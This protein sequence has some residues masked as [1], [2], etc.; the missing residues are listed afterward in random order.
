VSVALAGGATG[1]DFSAAPAISADGNRIAFTS[2]ATNVGVGLDLNGAGRDIFVRDMT[3]GTAVLASR[4]T[5][6]NGVSGNGLSERASISADGSRVAFES[7][8]TDLAP[9]DA[10]GAI[11]IF[12]RDTSAE[13]LE[14]VSGQSSDRNDT[15]SISGDGNCIAFGTFSDDLVPM[16][17]GTDHIRVVARA[18]RGDCP[19]GP[20]EDTT[21]GD[22]VAPVVSKVSIKPKRFL[23]GKKLRKKTKKRPAVGGRL[24]YTLSEAAK[25]SVRIDAKLKGKRVKG[26]CVKPRPRNRKRRRCNRFVRRGTLSANGKLGANRLNVTG[27]IKKRKLRPGRYRATITATDEAGNVSEPRPVSFKILRKRKTRR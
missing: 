14:R 23:A 5:G 27:L 4:T 25:V 22:T 2:G 13:T 1:N 24:R 3:A 16:P 9:G 26:R 18:L 12:V 17:P 20:A 21:T 15:P 11:D 10:N 6:A 7:S 8:S 19:F